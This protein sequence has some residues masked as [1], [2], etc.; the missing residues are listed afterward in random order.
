MA[1]FHF[2]SLPSLAMPS[3][4]PAPAVGG[5]DAARLLAGALSPV[6]SPAFAWEP[7]PAAEVVAWFPEYEV[8]AL[9][10]RGAMGAVYRAVQRK[11][12]RPVAIKL[13]PPE[14]AAREGAVTRFEREARAMARLQHPNIVALHD[15][16]RTAEG[17]LFIVMEYVDGADLSRLIH[18]E[19][20]GLGV[21]QALEIVGQVCD[22]LQ[23]A[24]SRGFV[25]R[26]I[27]P[28]NVL[29][30]TDGRVK[31]ADFGLAKLVARPSDAE[32]A[33]DSTLESRATLTG[34]ALGTPDYTAPEQLKGAPVDH[35]ADIYSLGVMLY[36]M[37]TGD[38]PRG[39]WTPPSQRTAAPAR[40]DAV[41]TRA[42]QSEPDNRYQQAS[43]VKAA[44]EGADATPQ[45]ATR[46][47]R[48]PAN[49]IF[50]LLMIACNVVMVFVTPTG[51]LLT[52][53]MSAGPFL[54]LAIYF[55]L[56]RK[57]VGLPSALL[58]GMVSGALICFALQQVN[59]PTPTEREIQEIRSLEMKLKDL[60]ADGYGREHPKAKKVLA[61]LEA[62]RQEE[63]SPGSSS[64]ASSNVENIAPTHDGRVAEI[65]VSPG[66]QASPE[67]SDNSSDKEPAQKNTGKNLEPVQPVPTALQFAEGR[68]AALSS[69][70]HLYLQ[71][72]GNEKAT[73][74]WR[75]KSP[76]ERY[77][78]IKSYLPYSPPALEAYTPQGFRFILPEEVTGVVMA[79]PV[80]E[81]EALIAAQRGRVQQLETDMR[82]LQEKYR[83]TDSVPLSPG[84]ADSAGS[85]RQSQSEFM[86]AKYRYESEMAALHEMEAA[87][88]R[89]RVDA[90]RQGQ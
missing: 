42:M 15:Y 10:G 54:A 40:L 51:D 82:A 67:A 50:V 23:Y 33:Q 47:H 65:K 78:L 34:Q 32:P 72:G 14:V 71:A 69:A 20:G 83:I 36:E 22:A 84:G 21:P 29:V 4:S 49:R 80:S 66:Q 55:R 58:A 1:H 3:H 43:E 18:A 75:R 25:H 2:A 38:L 26:D 19:G 12:E 87:E 90:V 28:G 17:H 13:L 70:T 8:Q 61:R 44:V 11:L 88:R 76:Q 59:Q 35:R 79:Q 16:G 27:K 53:L 74:E 62:L 5:L 85:D 60:E 77:E 30:D 73:G 63:S 24:H 39:A 56:R 81:K 6:S 57:P 89:E 52:L 86:Q 41:V 64:G 37:L 45:I 48:W 9:I 46:S 7:P 68:A 31:I